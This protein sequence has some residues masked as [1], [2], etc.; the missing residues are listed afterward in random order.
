MSSLR[1]RPWVAV[2]PPAG[3]WIE[4]RWQAASAIAPWVAPPAGA[5]IETPVATVALPSYASHPLRV[6][7]LKQSMRHTKRLGVVAPPAGAWIETLSR[8][9]TGRP[10]KSHP[11]RVRGL[12][13]NQ[14]HLRSPPCQSHPLRVRGLKH[15]HQ[16][17][18]SPNHESHPLRVRGLKRILRHKNRHSWR[19]APPAGAWIETS[20]SH[21][22]C[23]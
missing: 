23:N 11:L 19:V 9:P 13:P 15:C 1:L 18:P 3:A 8:T 16:R 17:I 10:W 6:R 14:S 2:A 4:T 21:D 12:K 5:W 22:I 7:G 20:L